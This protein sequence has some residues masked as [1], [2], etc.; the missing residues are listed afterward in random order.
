VRK[1]IYWFLVIVVCSFALVCIYLSGA[2]MLGAGFI[3]GDI[4]HTDAQRQ[5]A[6]GKADLFS[7]FCFICLCASVALLFLS[8]RIANLVL[9]TFGR[10]LDSS[11]K[12]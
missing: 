2:L 3:F 10:T 1:A 5:V 12:S 8:G 11:L 9:K 7:L 6:Q 4:D